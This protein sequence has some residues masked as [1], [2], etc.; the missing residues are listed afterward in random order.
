M[1]LN[2]ILLLACGAGLSALSHAL[3]LRGDIAP[4]AESGIS[5]ERL[6][7]H[8]AAIVVLLAAMACYVRVLAGIF[9]KKPMQEREGL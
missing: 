4:F 3:G 5:W 7:Y 1:N 6:T 2:T 8:L 9:R